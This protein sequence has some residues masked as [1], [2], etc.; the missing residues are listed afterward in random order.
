M[1]RVLGEVSA[2]S[3]SDDSYVEY[4]HESIDSA[5]AGGGRYVD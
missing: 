3:T 4:A 2:C 5:L 1:V